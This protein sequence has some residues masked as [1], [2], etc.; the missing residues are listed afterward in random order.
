M[1]DILQ[2]SQSILVVDDHILFREGLVGLFQ[3]APD[4]RVL[5]HAG[6]IKEAVEKAFHFKPDII[7]MDF[8]LPDGT[9]LD[10][11]ETILKELPECKIIFLTVYETNENLLEAVRLGAK[12]YLLKN[13][14]GASLLASLRAL[15]QGEI[16]MSRKM[17]SQI[18]EHSRSLSPHTAPKNLDKLS[19]RETDILFELRDGASNQQIAERLFLSENTVKHHIHSILEKLGV[20]NRREAGKLALQMDGKK[21]NTTR[22]K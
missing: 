16:A 19:P 15:A 9:G 22:T 20:E 17:L 14:T 2:T 18:V 7:L 13:V 12:G 8:S 6:T 10:A 5:D 11:T 3:S 4:F 21:N 1:N